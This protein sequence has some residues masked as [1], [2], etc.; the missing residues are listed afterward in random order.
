MNWALQIKDRDEFIRR[1]VENLP[2]RPAYF[3][4]DVQMNLAGATPLASLPE[5]RPLAEDE[6]QSAAARGAAVIDT[7][8]AAFFGAGHFP[9]SL[10][11]GLSSH[12][13]STW[14]GFLVPFGKPIALVVGRSRATIL[15][16]R[17]VR[18]VC[19]LRRMAF[20]GVAKAQAAICGP[21]ADSPCRAVAAEAP[22]AA[23]RTPIERK[24]R[25][26]GSPRK[27]T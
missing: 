14:A 7:R 23:R 19:V 21:M 17:G 16:P 12:L 27:L 5:L 1:M 6:L 24:R 26:G 13:F 8:N 11:I 2:E 25:R 15:L 18:M 9:G 22:F 10:N 3:A 20:L 4:H